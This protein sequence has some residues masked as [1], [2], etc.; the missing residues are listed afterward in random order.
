MKKRILIL[1]VAFMFCLTACDQ[2]ADD[3]PKEPDGQIEEEKDPADDDN[4]IS[5][6]MSGDNK[7]GEPSGDLNGEED[8]DDQQKGDNEAPAETVKIQVYC[9]ND[10]ATAFVTNEAEIDSLTPEKV[11]GAL[12]GQNVVP[13]DVQILNFEQTETDGMKSILIDFNGAFATYVSSMGSAGE[14]YAMGSVCNTFL[15]AFGCEQIKITVEN[16]TLET[17]HTDYPRYMTM[18]Q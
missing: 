9:S 4:D 13:G 17:G 5:G 12:I 6:D 15:D 16:A 1:I 7:G 8:D 10:D 3:P 2:G 11:L 18:Y 14:Y